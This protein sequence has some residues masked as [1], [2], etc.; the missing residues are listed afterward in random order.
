MTRRG[1]GK[2][3]AS[4][5]A[6]RE[7]GFKRVLFLVHRA[8]LAVQAKKSY[9]RVFGSTI[10]VGLVGAGYHEYDRDYVFATVETLNRDEHLQMYDPAE[11]DCIILDLIIA[12]Q[13]HIRRL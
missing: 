9:Q 11:F 13:I 10:S 7:I 6:M 5:F 1:T 2:T 3:Y 12:R 8:S 4:A